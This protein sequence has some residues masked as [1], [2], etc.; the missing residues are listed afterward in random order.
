MG[1]VINRT[2]E[3]GINNFGSEI[4]I[5]EYRTSKDIDVYF[6][7]YNWIAK[8]VQ[9]K[10]FKIGNVKC[11]YEKR[12]YEI[13]YLGEGKYKT[14]DENGLTLYYK[15][16]NSM[17]RRCYSKHFKNN[18]IT[19]K[20]STSCEEWLNFQN[21]GDWMENNYYEIEGEKMHLDKDILIKGNKIYSPE[22]CIF[23]PQKINDLFVKK[24]NMRGE[25]PIGVYYDKKNNKYKASCKVS[26]CRIYKT[27]STSDEAFKFYKKTKESYIKSM[28]ELYKHKIPNELYEAM[29]SYEVDIND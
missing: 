3:E 20:K 8:G 10:N 2:G 29:Y 19:Y 6:P 15:T 27:F 12:L 17:I 21:F 25:Y 23:V 22:T 16:W 5:A 1:K 26:D 24:D 9:Y 14:R 4:I 28:A 11:P 18:H 13:G 7:E